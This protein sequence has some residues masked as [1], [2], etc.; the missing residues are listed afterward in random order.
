VSILANF[1]PQIVGPLDSVLPGANSTF[2][3][4]A[5]SGC[6]PSRTQAAMLGIPA[7][8]R[9]TGKRTSPNS[10]GKVRRIGFILIEFA[11]MSSFRPQIAVLFAMR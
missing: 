9:P 2:R 4:H 10:G 8:P 11:N 1:P 5:A 7:I 6:I 3:T